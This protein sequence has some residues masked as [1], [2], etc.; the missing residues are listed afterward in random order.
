MQLNFDQLPK[1]TRVG[2]LIS[3][4]VRMDKQL[5]V[6]MSDEDFVETYTPSMERYANVVLLLATI[7]P[8]LVNAMSRA[9][10]NPDQAAAL[11]FSYDF[12]KKP[13]DEEWVARYTEASL[14]VD[15][16]CLWKCDK[17][18]DTIAIVRHTEPHGRYIIY[19]EDEIPISR[20]V[21]EA[22]KMGARRVR[23]Q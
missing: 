19:R 12:S 3:E 10:K 15:G 9:A 14:D 17:L 2:T 5:R 16:Y 13:R 23:R 1:P 4:A 21:H 22:R 6:A 20:L 7:K 8:E 18:G 11:Q